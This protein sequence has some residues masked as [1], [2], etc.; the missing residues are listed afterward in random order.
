MLPKNYLHAMP[1]T[2]Q[3]HLL[4]GVV[5]LQRSDQAAQIASRHLPVWGP[6]THLTFRN[7]QNF[8]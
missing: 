2:Q 8:P 3:A 1:A 4:P 5:G 6:V 7:F